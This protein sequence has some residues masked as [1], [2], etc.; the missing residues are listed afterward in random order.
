MNLVNPNNPANPQDFLGQQHNEAVSAVVST[1]GEQIAQIQDPH[2]KQQFIT[3]AVQ[4][5]V[6]SMFGYQGPVDAYFTQLPGYNGLLSQV[7]FENEY[8]AIID[9]FPD[10]YP[11]L[12]NRFRDLLNMVVV[13]PIETEDEVNNALNTILAFENQVISSGEGDET[14][15][16]AI[17]VTK[18][19]L[20]GWFMMPPIPGV[21]AKINWGAVTCDGIGLLVGGLG[22][23]VAGSTIYRLCTD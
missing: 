14:L 22:G 13:L 1:Y 7:D 16:G 6:E 8:T 4:S 5:T 11:W 3:S 19:S 2:A 10:L 23:A 21:E 12:R 18:Y 15:L 17:A 20:Y 9:C